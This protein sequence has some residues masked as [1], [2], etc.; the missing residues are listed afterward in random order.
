MTHTEAVEQAITTILEKDFPTAWVLVVEAI[1]EDG[2]PYLLHLVS[3]DMT[4]WKLQG[5]LNYTMSVTDLLL[6]AGEPEDH[7][8]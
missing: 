1:G 7:D 4:S 8:E 5:M 3:D 2:Q 6:D